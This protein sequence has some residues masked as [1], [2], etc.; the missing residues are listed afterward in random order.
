MALIEDDECRADI[1]RAGLTVMLANLDRQNSFHRYEAWAAAMT[2][3]DAYVVHAI[4]CTPTD[5]DLWA[6]LAM[7]RLAIAENPDELAWLMQRSIEYAP[8]EYAVLVPRFV[9]WRKA[10]A[11]SLAAAQDAVEADLLTLLTY[12]S[13][14][15][16]AATLA[17][18][19]TSL[20]PFIRAS[21]RLIPRDRRDGLFAAGLDPDLRPDAP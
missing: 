3:G 6:R 10:S 13:A 14:K 19:G 2:D 8:A 9:V 1:L 17:D 4:G 16:I 11:A 5:G 7:I 21:L 18:S 12:A 15:Q 20:K